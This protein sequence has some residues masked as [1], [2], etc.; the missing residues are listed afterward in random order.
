MYSGGSYAAMSGVPKSPFEGRSNHDG[1]NGSGPALIPALNPR[2][3]SIPLCSS[4]FVFSM[5]VTLG[6]MPK[7]RA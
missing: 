3:V 7:F 1:G 6:V 5:K 4:F 2:S